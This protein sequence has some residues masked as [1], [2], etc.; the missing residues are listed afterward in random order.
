MLQVINGKWDCKQRKLPRDEYNLD[1]IFFYLIFVLYT[2][3]DKK[4]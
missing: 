3:T 2:E 4:G 1:Y